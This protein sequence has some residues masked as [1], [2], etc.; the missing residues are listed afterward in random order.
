MRHTLIRTILLVVLGLFISQTVSAQTFQ[1]RGIRYNTWSGTT[2]SELPNYFDA[3]VPYSF[4]G[5]E[6]LGYGNGIFM[7]SGM[8]FMEGTT[9][10]TVDGIDY[11][12]LQ[13][14]VVYFSVGYYNPVLDGLAYAGYGF[15][16]DFGWAGV[17]SGNGSNGLNTFSMILGM[18]VIPPTRITSSISDAFT[19]I[20]L[21]EVDNGKITSAA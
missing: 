7:R 13:G 15:Y 5:V 1:F 8:S 20:G 12:V 16:T 14:S 18:R 2:H 11:Q 10:E 3:K 17:K 6:G 4:W 21:H 19:M 9:R